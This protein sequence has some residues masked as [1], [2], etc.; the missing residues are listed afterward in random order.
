ME[1]WVRGWQSERFQTCAVTISF[2]SATRARYD[3]TNTYLTITKIKN[4]SLN[5]VL[6]F[7]EMYT[8]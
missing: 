1:H 7:L 5:C 8:V 3:S 2:L 6:F 4:K